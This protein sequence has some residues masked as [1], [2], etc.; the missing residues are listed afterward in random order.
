MNHHMKLSTIFN[1]V[2]W[3]WDV[4]NFVF[5]ICGCVTFKKQ[6]HVYKLVMKNSLVFPTMY[7]FDQIN[8]TN[9]NICQ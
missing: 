8:F 4:L 9:R 3:F 5:N 6:T 1:V 2:L 7:D